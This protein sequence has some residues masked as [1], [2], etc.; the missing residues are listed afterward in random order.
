[1]KV[2][3]GLKNNG[4]TRMNIL[5]IEVLALSGVLYVRA[6]TVISNTGVVMPTVFPGAPS[7]T[8]WTNG[9]VT[10]MRDAYG[11][12]AF[13]STSASAVINNAIGNLT[14]GGEIFV[15]AGNYS[16]TSSIISKRNIPLI[17]RGEGRYCT[18]FNYSGPSGV[19]VLDFD[20][21]GFQDQQ[22]IVVQDLSI[23]LAGTYPNTIGVNLNNVYEV[24]FEN[25]RVQMLG[26]GVKTNSTCFYTENQGDSHVTLT[27]CDSV[28]F[29]TNFNIYADH[30]TMSKCAASYGVYGFEFHG[31][32]SDIT[33]I[34]LHAYNQIS[35]G[36]GFLID[37][38]YG[39]QLCLINPYSE[40][41]AGCATYD[42]VV[43]SRAANVTCVNLAAYRNP[44]VVVVS[45][46]SLARF[47]GGT[48]VTENSGSAVNAT[49]TTFSI[50]DGL[51]GTPT[52]V[53]CSFNST[54]IT[55]Y[56]WTVTSS[57]ITVTVVGMTGNT[58][59][60]WQAVYVP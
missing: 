6:T 48:Y 56:T 28:N 26:T 10:F 11:N 60:Y 36:D 43:S 12:I 35:G 9:T 41:P 42:Y 50:T 46:G 37:Y 13:Q 19:S 21:G 25:V 18:T 51:A 54:E 15:N 30:V 52:G 33:G 3:F 53:W 59:C 40:N 4:K 17:L 16:L 20:S 14:N 29:E 49:A 38:S 45:P 31:G 27:D 22:S 55:A 57:T 8:V 24:E 58:T 39:G 2:G 1:M 44:P 32:G 34:D 23:Q 7:Y 47:V 5:L